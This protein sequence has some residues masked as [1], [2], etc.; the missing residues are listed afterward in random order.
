MRV[1]MGDLECLPGRQRRGLVL[2]ESYPQ[3]RVGKP[4]LSD[5]PKLSLV[6][7]K[8]WHLHRHSNGIVPVRVCIVVFAA[9]SASTGF[10]SNTNE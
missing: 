9:V 1:G 4:A 6:N 8:E 7:M 2:P 5:G 10:L 3:G